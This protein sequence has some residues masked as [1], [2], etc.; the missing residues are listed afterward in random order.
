MADI[1]TF[2][3][4]DNSTGK[5]ELT[6]KITEC[7]LQFSRTC[8]CWLPHADARCEQ[9][10]VHVVSS[11]DKVLNLVEYFVE[12]TA[13]SG[14]LKFKTFEAKSNADVVTQE[15]EIDNAYCSSISEKYSIGDKRQRE[16]IMVLVPKTVKIM[17][18]KFPRPI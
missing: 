3:I 1:S 5:Y 10:E 11:E 14:T 16:F 8:E 15:V 4:G 13:L 7:H 9:I 18:V 6:Y 2:Q 17:D 12:G